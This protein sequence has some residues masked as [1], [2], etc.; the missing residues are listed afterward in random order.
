MSVCPGG[1]APCG[2]HSLC[3]WSVTA[4]PPHT[5][6]KLMDLFKPVLLPY[7]YLLPDIYVAHTSIGKQA[8]GLQLKSF[9]VLHRLS[10]TKAVT[11]LVIYEI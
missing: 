2:H 8:T 9:L 3:H 10:H 6:T 1:G 11:K 7:G 5:H 4:P